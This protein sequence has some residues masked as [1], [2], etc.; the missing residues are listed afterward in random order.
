MF[1][2]EEHPSTLVGPGLSVFW[3]ILNLL[4]VKFVPKRAPYMVHLLLFI[5]AVE[6]VAFK[7]KVIPA[8]VEG[9]DPMTNTSKMYSYL[10]ICQC[11]NYTPFLAT[12]I[13]YPL[14]CIPARYLELMKNFEENVNPYSGEPF[15]E[16]SS[17]FS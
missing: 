5:Q 6:R 15:K 1:L 4:A 3:S 17:Y 12:L 16:N 11:L 8:L 10:I 7:H 14:I 2:K 13:S 9:V